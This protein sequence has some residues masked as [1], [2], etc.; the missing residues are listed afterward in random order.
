MADGQTCSM[1]R[2]DCFRVQASCSCYGGTQGVWN[3]TVGMWPGVHSVHI[4]KML[5]GHL[6]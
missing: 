6:A 1:A 3:A 4:R 5:G 2:H